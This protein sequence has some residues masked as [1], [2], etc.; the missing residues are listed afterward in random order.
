MDDKDLAALN[1]RLDTIEQRLRISSET[2]QRVSNRLQRRLYAQVEAL[3]GLYRD[4]DGLPALPPLRNWALSPDTA[5]VIHALIRSYRPRHVMEC[6]SGASSVMLGH[7][8]AAGVIDRVTSIEHEPMYLE[9]SRQQLHRAGVLDMVDL[10]FCPLIERR[11]GDRTAIWY[12]VDVADLDPVDLVIVDG[13][14]SNTGPQARYP[15]VPILE[16][17]MNPGC[18]IVVDD[19]ERPDEVAMVEAW[20]DQFPCE[21]IT[22]DHTVEKALAVLEYRPDEGPPT[23]HKETQDA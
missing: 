18:L 2:T 14:P 8:K 20:R 17:V 15:V 19:Y 6:G 10:R 11:A 3:I 7:L 1:R 23:L 16:A 12:D 5:R 22:L 13:P 4:L 21:L 9:L